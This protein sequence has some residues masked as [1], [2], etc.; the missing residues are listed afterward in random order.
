M[1]ERQT[2]T[3]S[4]SK[5]QKQTDIQRQG[6][7]DRKKETDKENTASIAERKSLKRHEK[8]KRDRK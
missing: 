2:E 1:R 3:A 8:K 7:R 4:V 5:R 6:N